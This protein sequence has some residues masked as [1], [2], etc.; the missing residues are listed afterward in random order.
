MAR[1]NIYIGRHVCT[2]PRA[3]KEADAL[4]AAGH[5]VCVCGLWSD[6]RLVARDRALLRTRAWRF[7]PFADCRPETSGGYWRW[8]RLR[9]ASRLARE[10]FSRTGRVTPDLFGYGTRSLANHARRHVAEL[11]IFHSEGGLWAA[12]QLRRR[13]RRVGV[14]FEDWFSRDLPACA[15]RHRPIAALS[16]LEAAAL[17]TDTYVLAASEAVSAGFAAAFGRRAAAVV[18]NL[19]PP[20]PAAPVLERDR[21]DP[22]KCSFHWFSQTIGEGRGLECLFDALGQVRGSWELHLRA[23]DPHGFL[24][25][26]VGR[27]PPS[28]QPQVHLHPTVT[29]AHLAARIAQHDVGLALEP[30]SSP[31][32]DLTVSNK[33]FQYLQAGLAVAA[34][35]TTGHREVLGQIAG[36]DMLFPIGDASALARLLDRYLSDRSAL[37]HARRI[38]HEGYQALYTRTNPPATCANLAARALA[39]PPAHAHPAHV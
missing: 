6:P 11:A 21:I 9:M 31:N 7:V 34:S 26:L 4:G 16:D 18:Y 23:D 12:A 28:L 35:D 2:A 37:A 8:W 32:N 33:L 27:L 25:Y 13:G 22:A 5:D 38:A 30:A 17:R 39:S 1:I 36:N 24:Q 15:R 3:I 20:E 19:F 10:W 14:D 29:N